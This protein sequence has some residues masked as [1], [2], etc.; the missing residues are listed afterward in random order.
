[1]IT[2]MPRRLVVFGARLVFTSP[3]QDDVP[4]LKSLLTK[5]NI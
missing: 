5:C 2:F 4:R 1:V 3:L